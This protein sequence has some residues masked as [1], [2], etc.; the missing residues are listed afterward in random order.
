MLS[1]TVT[2]MSHDTTSGYLD[3]SFAFNP[4]PDYLTF[5]KL[6]MSFQDLDLLPS[7]FSKVTFF[8]TARIM[9]GSTIIANL[10]ETYAHNNGIIV[11]NN[12]RTDFMFDLVPALFSTLP[13]PFVIEMRLKT[14]LTNNGLWERTLKNTQESILSAHLEVVAAPV[15]EPGTLSLLGFGLTGMFALRRK[16]RKKV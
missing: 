14:N 11:T 13:D 6:F 9:S 3:L 2:L 1:D 4:I 5:A 16:I 15:P 10:N 8:E 7:T 12:T